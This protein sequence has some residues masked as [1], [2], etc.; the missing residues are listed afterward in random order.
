MPLYE[1]DCE[2]CQKHMEVI[3]KFSDA[4]LQECPDCKGVLV[5]RLSL[6]SFQLKGTG[7]YNTDYRKPSGTLEKG[8]DKT[9]KGKS[10][11]TPSASEKK[12]KAKE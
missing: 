2:K 6:T 7:W 8:T 11:E 12:E 4:P 1:Y 3:Q 9:D 5:K 10:A